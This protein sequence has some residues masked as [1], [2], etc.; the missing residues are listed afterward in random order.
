MVDES[1]NNLQSKQQLQDNKS[2]NNK[3]WLFQALPLF[4]GI[5]IIVSLLTIDFTGSVSQGD[6]TGMS[7]ATGMTPK[8]MPKQCRSDVD[9]NP[10][11][12]CYDSGAIKVCMKLTF[13]K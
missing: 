5:I 3:R 12:I 8:P 4:I 6:I 10:D 13:I 1:L 11:E 9:C 7:V 2:G